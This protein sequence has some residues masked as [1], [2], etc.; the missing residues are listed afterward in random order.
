MIQDEIPE[1]KPCPF[2]NKPITIGREFNMLFERYFIFI[3]CETPN[4]WLSLENQWTEDE[5]E[6]MKKYWNMRG[7]DFK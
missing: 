3:Y 2:C 1:F 5:I 7:E 4:C 6:K